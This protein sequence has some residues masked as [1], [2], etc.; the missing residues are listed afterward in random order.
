[1][2]S[3]HRICGRQALLPKSLAIP[4]C[5]NPTETPLCHGGF[6]DVWKGQYD[7]REVAVK[8]LKVY[9][10]SNFEKIR[11]V[12]PLRLSRAPANLP[13][14]PDVLQGGRNMEDP[15]SSKCVTTVG[16][17]DDRGPVR[18]GIGVDGQWEHQRV[19]G[20]A[21][22]RGSIEACAYSIQDPYPLLS[23]TVR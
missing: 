17:D 11:K 6:A 12:D 14:F 15:S 22:R 13:R 23:L 8:V 7:G 3:L 16:G 21:R 9:R 18:D 4:L 5:Y 2:R 20:A 1:V 19:C 10:T